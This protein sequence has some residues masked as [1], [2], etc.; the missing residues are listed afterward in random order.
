MRKEEFFLS[1]LIAFVLLSVLA[2]SLFSCSAL[3]R[4]ER[5]KQ[6]AEKKIIKALKKSR[7]SVA[8]LTRDTFPCS[9]LLK[10]DTT[11]FVYDSLIY[12]ECPD[13]ETGK[14]KHDTLYTDTAGT[15]KTI[16]VPYHLPIKIKIIDRWFEDSAKISIYKDSLVME[17]IITGAALKRERKTNETVITQQEKIKRRGNTIL[18]LIICILVFAGIIALMARKILTKK[19]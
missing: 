16:L 15:V 7:I 5:K 3:R 1:K 17:R 8:K 14:V 19:I 4:T 11:V 9:D 13:Y 2:I 10:T 18:W 12:I 6:H